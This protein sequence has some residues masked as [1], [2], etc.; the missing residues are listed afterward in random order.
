MTWLYPSPQMFYNAL[1]RKGKGNDVQEEDMEAVVRAHNSMNETTWQRVY[2][3]EQLHLDECG[4]PTLLRFQGKPDQLSP[5]ARLRQLLGGPLPFDRHDWFVD[6]CG[7]EV[8][9]VIDFYFNEDKAG[10]PEAFDLVV[11]PALDST[12]A[13]VDRL[14][15][16]IYTKFAQWGLPCPVTG[17]EGKVGP[18]TS[19][20]SGETGANTQT[21]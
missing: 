12:E 16:L 2:E 15:M 6:R 1:K 21:V 4:S 17:H 18:A 14:R 19:R 8:R 9:Y 10:T 13:A 20:V 7:K 11:R 3:W 5:L